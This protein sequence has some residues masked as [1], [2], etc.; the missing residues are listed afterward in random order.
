MRRLSFLVSC[1]LLGLLMGPLAAQVFT[2]KPQVLAPRAPAPQTNS[3]TGP[4]FDPA[5]DPDRARA[6][7]QRLKTANRQLR[8]AFGTTLAELQNLRVQLDETTRP[9][10]SLVTA[11]CV[12]QFVSQ[13]SAGA[14]EDCAASGYA[15]AAV[16]GL[17]HRTCN[18]TTMC[19]PG[20]ACNMDNHRCE[21][22]PPATDD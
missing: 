15:C 12:G 7:I 16:S 9:G 21:L 17:C 8:Q 10:G 6:E 18:S 13:N 1:L 5:L 20:F 22:P 2:V 14:S 11:H 4:Q 19:A 3:A